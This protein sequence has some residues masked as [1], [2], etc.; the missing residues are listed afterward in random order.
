MG[1]GKHWRHQVK[2]GHQQYRWV[3]EED[4]LQSSEFKVTVV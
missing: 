2:Q 3:V 4:R 1:L